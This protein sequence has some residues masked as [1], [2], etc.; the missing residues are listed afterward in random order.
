MAIT[1]KGKISTSEIVVNFF[2]NN[3][4]SPHKI[5]EYYRGGANVPNNQGNAKIP[6]TGPIKW[7][8]FYGAGVQDQYKWQIPELCTDYFHNFTRENNGWDDLQDNPKEYVGRNNTLG[9][10]EI[11]CY[12][13]YNEITIP[14]L[15][16]ET[17]T[18]LGEDTKYERL[19]KNYAKQDGAEFF[20]AGTWKLTV[21]KRMKR[22][23]IVATAGGGAGS[24]AKT[25]F[26]NADLKNKTLT[27]TIDRGMDGEETSVWSDGFSVTVPG[28]KGG[29]VDGSPFISPSDMKD[30][31][32]TGG[33][34]TTQI[35]SFRNTPEEVAYSSG[36][37]SLINNEISFANNGVPINIVY[38]D[39][40]RIGKIHS[41]IAIGG[42]G[43]DSIYGI[44]S[45][46]HVEIPIPGSY[47][48]RDA[49]STNYI[50]NQQVPAG[51]GGNAGQHGGRGK[52][53]SF[54]TT[55]GGDGAMTAYL[56]DFETSPGDIIHIKA[57]RG[58][59][60]AI[61]T[62]NE[63]NTLG[64]ST[65]QSYSASSEGGEGR[66]ELWGSYGNYFSTMTHSGWILEDSEGLVIAKSYSAATS[67]KGIDTFQN[68][69]TS[70]TTVKVL[71]GTRTAP[72]KYFL[73]FSS[74]ISKNGDL[75]LKNRFCHI[76]DKFVTV[77]GI[78]EVLTTNPIPQSLYIEPDGGSDIEEVTGNPANWSSVDEE[79]Q[80]NWAIP[81]C[82]VV[83]VTTKGTDT[84]HANTAKFNLIESTSPEG[85]IGKSPKSITLG[86]NA[87]TQE[88]VIAQQEVYELDTS[89]LTSTIFDGNSTRELYSW[90]KNGTEHVLEDGTGSNFASS[91]SSVLA[92]GDLGTK[93][94]GMCTGGFYVLN[95]KTRFS[96]SI[97][98]PILPVVPDFINLI[99]ASNA[100]GY[101]LLEHA[102]FAGWTASKK[103]NISVRVNENIF[104]HGI[105]YGYNERHGA[106]GQDDRPGETKGLSSFLIPE[107]LSD[108]SI[109][110]NNYGKIIGLGGYGARPASASPSNR[111][112]GHDGGDAIENQST[113]SVIINNYSTGWIAGG[114]G[115]GGI[116]NGST[117]GGGAGQR[118]YQASGAAHAGGHSGFWR[119]TSDDDKRGAQ[120]GG[121]GLPGVF[122]GSLT[123]QYE[124]GG[125]DVRQA[126]A[127]A[128]GQGQQ[129]GQSYAK[130]GGGGG[131][132][133]SGGHADNYLGGVGGAATSGQKLTLNDLGGTV[134][135]QVE[136]NMIQ[137]KY[138]LTGGGAGGNGGS[139]SGANGSPYQGYS[140][141]GNGGGAG[142]MSKGTAQL[143]VGTVISFTL[144]AG[145][146]GGGGTGGSGV[147]SSMS[148]GIT[149]SV[150]GGQPNGGGS[151]TSSICG[152]VGCTSS[153]GGGAG[154]T[155][156]AAQWGRDSQSYP[157]GG[158]GGSGASAW[159][160]ASGPEGGT[161]AGGS[162]NTAGSAGSGGVA[163]I[164]GITYSSSGS[165]TVF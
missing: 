70:E 87:G 150:I 37:S 102:Q 58:G 139:G 144:G 79:T 97:E 23:R 16:I 104:V 20:P 165:H 146:V 71:G 51:A 56:G 91:S 154:Q 156:P 96:G 92:D 98:L 121:A 145:G 101:N 38:R 127:K 131:W 149:A 151:G 77:K 73:R 8:N 59:Q 93:I 138:S 124:T 160:R 42:K 88:H 158:H 35:L 25:T 162:G 95:D 161:P 2:P 141:S 90:V 157:A 82:N 61:E 7:S 36:I 75:E 105:A 155:N 17:G 53:I 110:I 55:D 84:V 64:N 86:P 78:A 62:F 24:T 100:A 4:S 76:G 10:I 40:Q 137:V 41:A 140:T 119:N 30:I 54:T 143:D 130:M 147:G 18:V 1:K 153:A 117:G 126:T 22:L 148:G 116:K 164:Q 68:S 39:D 9:S 107:A 114:G 45:S 52:D 120:A 5:S 135:G 72:R 128:G 32:V 60:Q 103:Q 13:A 66:V 12:H 81:K 99:V 69:T 159:G 27:A 132:A 26:S 118:I 15:T 125:G 14:A 129:A 11:L 29:G 28:G 31:Q 48:A 57:G 47:A 163:V 80:N 106:V 63:W 50:G 142:Q 74:R 46:P 44:G 122:T 83:F 6:T 134:Y 89:G 33:I 49:L 65:Y 85:W 21:P 109:T 152:G 112:F 94:S 43:G 34:K 67:V 111:R 3:N 19:Y 113:G 136:R 108:V 133:S 115:G 123:I